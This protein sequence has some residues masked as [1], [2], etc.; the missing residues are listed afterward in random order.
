MDTMTLIGIL[1][2]V[3]G[4]ILVGIEIVLPGFSVPGVSGI[5]CLVVGVF[6]LADTVTEGVFITIAVLAL[7]GILMAVLLW[8][9][10]KGKLRTPLILKEEQNREEGYLSSSDLNYLLNKKGYAVTDLRPAGVGN[11]DEIKFD[12][13]SEG[14]YISKG[15]EIQIIKVEGSKLVVREIRK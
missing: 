6:L 3:A 8:L 14:N 10:S 7:L 9:L 2:L 15:A 13:M 1:L 4:F 11:I 12:V 5:I